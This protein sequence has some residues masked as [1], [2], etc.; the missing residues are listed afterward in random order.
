MKNTLLRV[1]NSRIA[2]VL[3]L[4]LV[5]FLFGGLSFAGTQK[6]RAEQSE[7]EGQISKKTDDQL[8]VFTESEIELT[9]GQVGLL[10]KHFEEE[11]FGGTIQGWMDIAKVEVVKVEPNKVT[12]LILEEHSTGTINDEPI[13]HFKSG[14][15]VKFSQDHSQHR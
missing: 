11:L 10:H 12:F 1:Q 9:I 2:F 13:D 4:T 8:T 15:R 14:K 7:W 5:V 3:L 6:V